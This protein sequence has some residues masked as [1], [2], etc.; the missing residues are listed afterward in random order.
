MKYIIVMDN[1]DDLESGYESVFIGPFDF[2]IEALA[3]G[4]KSIKKHG[5]QI[6]EL[7]AYDPDNMPLFTGDFKRMKPKIQRFLN[8]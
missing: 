2:H 8:K 3:A 4:Q 1:T 5:W 7:V 6:K